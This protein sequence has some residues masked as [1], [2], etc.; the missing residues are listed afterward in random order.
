ML[1]WVKTED[2]KPDNYDDVL[3]DYD[4]K[5]A[6]VT[7]ISGAWCMPDGIVMVREPDGWAKL[8]SPVYFSH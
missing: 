4:G 6:V 2:R 7:Y 3:A 8:E 5:L 1:D